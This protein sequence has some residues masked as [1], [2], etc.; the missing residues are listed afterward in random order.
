MD[1][2]NNTKNADGTGSMDNNANSKNAYAK[3]D[4]SIYNVASANTSAN[5]GEAVIIKKKIGSNKNNTG[6][7]QSSKVNRANKNR[8]SGAN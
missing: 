5:T 1:N 3:A 6:I 8:V 2:I 4:F 7:S